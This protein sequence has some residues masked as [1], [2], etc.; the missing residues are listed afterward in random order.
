MI[1]PEK[2]FHSEIYLSSYSANTLFCAV[3]GLRC[4]L[5]RSGDN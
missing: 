1:R 2:R 5:C 3:I 4:A